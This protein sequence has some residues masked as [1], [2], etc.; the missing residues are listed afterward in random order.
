MNKVL[1]SILSLVFVA[2]SC[3]KEI[4]TTYLITKSSIGKLEKGSLARDLEVIFDQDS[5]VRDTVKLL[6]GFGAT[7]IKIF[8]KGGNHLL[9]LTPSADSIPII[10]NVNV[11]DARFQTENGIGMNSTFKDIK[12]KYTIKKIQTS[13]NNVVVFVKNSDVYFTIDKKELPSS[14]QYISSI[15]IEAVQIPDGAR[16]KYMMVGWENP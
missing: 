2:I 6:Q 8:E 12:E 9:T 14:L 4:D 13:L 10:E 15:N 1:F 5:I 11:R 16:I 7:K 3:K